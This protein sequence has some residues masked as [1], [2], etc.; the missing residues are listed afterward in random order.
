MQAV[1]SAW[2]A[3][4]DLTANMARSNAAR[5][6]LNEFELSHWDAV[7]SYQEATQDAITQEVSHIVKCDCN[8]DLDAVL[9]LAAYF[10]QDCIMCVQDDNSASLMFQ[11]GSIQD[12]G[13]LQIVSR[14]QAYKA[15]HYTYFRGAYYICE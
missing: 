3:T 9:D 12:L 5:S 14:S 8:D 15:G 13:T 7:G 4:N 6:F 11:D 10:E 2:R 1:F